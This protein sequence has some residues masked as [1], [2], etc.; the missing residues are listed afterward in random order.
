[1]LDMNI[2]FSDFFEVSTESLEEYGAFN[3]TLLNDLPLFVDPFLLFNSDITQYQK[4]HDEIIR[5]M[6][7]LK[8]I[9]AVGNITEALLKA[10][11]TFPEVSQNWLG[12]SKEGNQGHGLGMDFAIALNRNLNTVFRNFGEETVT[13]SSHLEKLCLIKTG[14]GRDNVSDFTTNLIKDF[15]GNYTQEYAIK[16]INQKFRRKIQ[17]PKAFFNYNT[18]SWVTKTYELPFINGDYVLL[19]PKD[20]LTKDDT[21]INRPDLISNVEEISEALPNDVLRTQVSRYLV[22]VLPRDPKEKRDAVNEALSSVIEKFPEI[23]DYYIRDKED[24]GQEAKSISKERVAYI[25]AVFVDQIRRF[26][27]THL[28]PIGF[29]K[30]G[31]NTYDEARERLLF[32][33]NVIENKGGHR[34]FYI[35]DKPIESESVLHILYRLTWFASL[36]NFSREVNDGRGPV[37]FMISRGSKDKTL[38]EF[39]L[40]KNP[41]LERNL[42]KQVK[43]YEAAS[44]PTHPSLKAIFYFTDEQLER[45]RRI[46]DRL[47]LSNN[48][49]IIL[50]DARAANKPSGSKA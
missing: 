19:T 4:L 25:Q 46:L 45:V 27:D 9:S 43:V 33:K 26:V 13:K 30:I 11:F 7:F 18:S 40:A 16:N 15:L 49:H 6:R 10:W 31:G 44:D 48:P 20:I 12:F 36:S 42:E 8:E 29:Y 3:I 47:G 23:L 39:K 21:W 34:F 24:N 28:E 32:L 41:Q 5:Y 38:V 17:V 50:I 1:M 35:D 2:Y 22:E 37:D 14:V